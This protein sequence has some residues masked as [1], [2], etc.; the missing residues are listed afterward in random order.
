VRRKSSRFTAFIASVGCTHF[1][2]A[3]N[4]WICGKHFIKYPLGAVICENHFG[5]G[6]SNLV[7]LLIPFKM[8]SKIAGLNEILE[9]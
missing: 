1:C 9:L 5:L 8:Q 3:D 4:L 7:V 2:R 6:I